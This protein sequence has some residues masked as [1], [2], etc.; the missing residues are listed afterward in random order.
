[1]ATID[2]LYKLTRRLGYQYRR[3]RSLN[4]PPIFMQIVREVMLTMHEVTLPGPNDN[5]Q[6]AIAKA[7][8]QHAQCFDFLAAL[9]ALPFVP[10]LPLAT[11]HA[12]DED[13]VEPAQ[14]KNEEPSL[15]ATKPA[16]AQPDKGD[17]DLATDNGN[18]Q[19]SDANEEPTLAQRSDE[20]N[21]ATS[22]AIAFRRGLRRFGGDD[23]TAY[24]NTVSDIKVA[25]T[26]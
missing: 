5:L 2:K 6:Q 12:D 21:L 4:L 13:S 22:S 11:A 14:E 9:A 18:G 3:H 15:L 10:G 16:E 19:Q 24:R 23:T 20:E 26:K 17:E 25:Q 1:M 8:S 7:P